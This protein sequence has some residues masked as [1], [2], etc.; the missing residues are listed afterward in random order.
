MIQIRGK[1]LSVS[2]GIAE[3]CIIKKHGTCESCSTCPKKTGIQD[4]VKVRTI[5]GIQ[6]GQEVVL[7]SKRNLFTRNKIMLAVIAFVFG[8][9]MTEIIASTAALTFYR[10]E[11]DILG[12]CISMFLL[13]LI[14]WMK[15]PKDL[16]TIQLIEGKNT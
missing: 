16:Y 11:V 12:G 9:I 6:V 1:I 3:V 5:Q 7:L 13:L 10:T 14:V 8:I 4:V 15:S 2:G